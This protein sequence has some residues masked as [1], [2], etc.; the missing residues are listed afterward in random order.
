MADA[1]VLNDAD[2]VGTWTDSSGLGNNATQGTA[3]FKPL[4]KVG[5]LNGKPVVRFDGTDD[6]IGP[7]LTVAQPDTIFIVL[8]N[9][10]VNDKHFVDTSGANRQLI[11]VSGGVQTMYAG[12]ALVSGPDSVTAFQIL[13]GVFNGTSSKLYRNGQQ[14]GAGNAGT[15]SSTDILIG[16]IG[17]AF[18]DCAEVLICEALLS[19]S[20]LRGVH[21]YLGQKYALPFQ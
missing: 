11:G 17:G 7:T 20:Q 9:N 16:G 14:I 4:Y 3:G 15:N 13:T 21:K 2:P 5:I 1:L 12:G 18:M 8:S 6:K 10:G 19:D